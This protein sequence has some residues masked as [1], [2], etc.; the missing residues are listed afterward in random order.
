MRFASPPKRRAWQS[1]QVLSLSGF[2]SSEFPLADGAGAI[3]TAAGSGIATARVP[4]AKTSRSRLSTLISRI[5]SGACHIQARDAR[6]GG[7]VRVIER[8]VKRV[9][10]ERVGIIFV[11]LD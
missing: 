8:G 11:K 4:G 10:G 6:G 2:P 9:W 3:A 7:R 5:P 1:T